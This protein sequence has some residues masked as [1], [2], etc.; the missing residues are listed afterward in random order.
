M[1][2]VVFAI[3]A[4]LFWGVGE[5][6]A[7][8]VLHTGKIGP[9]A[10]VAIR[11]SLALPIIWIAFWI[12]NKASPNRAGLGVGTLTMKEWVLLLGGSGVIAGAFAMIAFYV[13]ISLG[14]VS[15]MKPIAFSIAPAS[16]VLLGS[17]FL[18][19]AL[20]TRKLL[21]LG[22]VLSGV[23]LMSL[24][25]APKPANPGTDAPNTSHPRAADT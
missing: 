20:S 10:A 6:C 18:D 4:G 3:L 8:A 14:E 19:E 25:S 24:E 11:T 17:L 21:A 22:L 9:F 5:V 13:S 16:V 15:R 2:A 1:P 12:A 7:K 23:L